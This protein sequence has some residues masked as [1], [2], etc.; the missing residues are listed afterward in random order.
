MDSEF[1]PELTFRDYMQIAD[2]RKWWI[3]GVFA[4]VVIGTLLLTLRATPQ[5]RATSTV[6]VKGSVVQDVVATGGVVA[7]RRELNNALVFARS[8]TVRTDA[9]IRGL[10]A[11]GLID[12]SAAADPDSDIIIFTAT[13]ADADQVAGAA[14]S[15]ADSYVALSRERSLQSYDDAV[16]VVLARLDD[17]ATRRAT[18]LEALT[19]LDAKLASLAPDAPTRP[20]VEQERAAM[21]S[22]LA[23]VIAALDAEADSLSRAQANLSLSTGLVDASSATVTMRAQVPG[24]PFSPQVFRNLVLAVA[25]GLILGVAAALMINAFDTRVTDLASLEDATHRPDILKVAIPP[26]SGKGEAALEIIRDP[27]GPGA[28]AYRTL[29]AGVQFSALSREVGTIL[30]TSANQSEGKTTVAANLAQSLALLGGRVILVDFDLRRPRLHEVAG[31]ALSPG[32]TEVM[33]GDAEL[34]AVS[35]LPFGGTLTVVPSGSLPPNPSEVLAAPPAEKLIRDL[36]VEADYVIIDAAPVLPVADATLLAGL[37]DLTVLVA[38]SRATSRSD[39]AAA[40]GRLDRAGADLWA[41]VLV[42]DR[43][44]GGR[45]GYGYS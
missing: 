24:A 29:R 19:E 15:W 42:G 34:A 39:L 45:Y 37:V 41:V 12:A 22:Q 35:H 1:S 38:R 11:D 33:L 17:L 23:P 7:S 28:E 10:E 8:D 32:A 13:G 4:L 14:N 9:G 30:V 36:S 44:S 25:V 16:S 6:L 31:L 27:S 21:A 20:S 40:A 43:T 18:K 5:Y 26:L 2:R 3:I